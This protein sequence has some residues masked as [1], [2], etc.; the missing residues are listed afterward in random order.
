MAKT[1]LDA[2]YYRKNSSIRFIVINSAVLIALTVLLYN[3]SY[4][5]RH[6]AAIA[7]GLT[8]VIY[9]FLT[10]G[11]IGG[12]I[13]GLVFMLGSIFLSFSAEGTA[14]T[15]FYF[16]AV[17]CAAFVWYFNGLIDN[18]DER[19][20]HN[21]LMENEIDSDRI[22]SGDRLKKLNDAISA[23]VGKI[24][25]YR[26]LNRVAEELLSTLDRNKIVGVINK[27]LAGLIGEKEVT[28]MLLV[29]NRESDTFS[30]AVEPK[31]NEISQRETVNLYKKDPFD[32]WI[33]KNKY[34]LLIKN[35]DDDFRFRNL[36]RDWIH[37]KSLI[38]IP[39]F[40]TKR[41]IGILK[42]YSEKQDVFD[43][44]DARLL[45][46][47]GDMC[48]SVVENS[49]LY[50]KT[51]TL[52][53]QDGLTGLYIRRYFIEKMDEEMKRSKQ[54]K[55]SFSYLMIDIDHFKDCNDNYGHLFGDKVLKCLG[56]FLMVNLRDVDLVGRY[57]GEEFAI[58]LPSTNSN[59][60]RF[61]A[62]RLRDGFSKMIVAVDEKQGIKLTLSLG[63][64]EF[65]AGDSLKLMEIINRADKALYYSKENGRNKVTFWEDLNDE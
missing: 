43:N 16:I 29:K 56:D 42:F 38:A 1:V 64:V 45:N 24:E 61:V 14:R 31:K 19:E 3:I 28:P 59:G 11:K 13:F 21:N 65:K 34:T 58:V 51:E 10:M 46:Y 2:F 18:L 25:N 36:R 41:L 39:L 7:M 35:I 60:A 40:E 27:Y 48:S 50:E 15:P 55:S 26:M 54:A 8:L 5:S 22:V 32:E 49:M 57:G 62:E 30:P 4:T 20:Q 33:I 6:A 9:A 23:N 63:G 44:E 12:G 52:A 37:F 17:F 47:L 53:T